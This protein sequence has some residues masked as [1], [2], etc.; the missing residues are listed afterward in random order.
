MYFIFFMFYVKNFP[1]EQSERNVISVTIPNPANLINPIQT[2]PSSAFM[3][4][5]SKFPSAIP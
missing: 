3:F 1:A 4:L 5:M 2:S